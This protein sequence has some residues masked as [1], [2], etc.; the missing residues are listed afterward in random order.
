MGDELI[1]LVYVVEVNVCVVEFM[2]LNM[3]MNLGYL[4]RLLGK[5]KLLVLDGY[6]FYLVVYERLKLYFEIKYFFIFIGLSKDW[7]FKWFIEYLEELFNW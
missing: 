2:G 3:N 1:C 6:L 7:E 4:F 5:N